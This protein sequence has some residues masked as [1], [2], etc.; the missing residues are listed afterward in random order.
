MKVNVRHFHGFFQ[1]KSV[2]VSSESL[3]VIVTYIF[4]EVLL[5]QHFYYKRQFRFL[6]LLFSPKPLGE[7]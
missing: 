2:P 4:C 6:T 7:Q 3:T 1:D 5:L